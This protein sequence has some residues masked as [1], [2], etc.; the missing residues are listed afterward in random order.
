MSFLSLFVFYR[1]TF[2][3]FSTC[4]FCVYLPI[5]PQSVPILPIGR[6]W[7]TQEAC[8]LCPGLLFCLY[9]PIAFCLYWGL[10]IYIYIYTIGPRLSGRPWALRTAPVSADGHL[11]YCI[12]R[13]SGWMFLCHCQLQARAQ[14]IS[15]KLVCRLVAHAFAQ[16]VKG[17]R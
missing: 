7:A 13:V 2:F 17:R 16:N 11:S 15:R 10:Y 5:L 6:S 12:I 9:L 8:H 14:F 1:T 3:N 4:L